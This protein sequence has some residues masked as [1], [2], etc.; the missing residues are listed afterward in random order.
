MAG[1]GEILHILKIFE[2]LPL[3]TKNS[4]EKLIVEGAITHLEL[5]SPMFGEKCRSKFMCEFQW[6]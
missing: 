6:N 1:A 4:R 3:T 2:N 5:R